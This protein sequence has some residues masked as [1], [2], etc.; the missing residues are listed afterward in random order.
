MGRNFISIFTLLI[1]LSMVNAIPHRLH[2][3]ATTFIQCASD[4]PILNVTL[5]PYPVIPGVNITFTI[6]GT[7]AVDITTGSTI[8]FGFFVTGTSTFIGI[9]TYLDFCSFASCPK[10]AGVSFLTVLEAPAPESLP[11]S[12]TLMILIMAQL[13][14]FF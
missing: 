7:P 6:E 10:L 12:Y 3:R 13:L 14:M 2:K 9:P 4:V 5:F 8:G 1:I 11:T